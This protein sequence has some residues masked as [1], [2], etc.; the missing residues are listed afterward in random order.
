MLDAS[1]FDY[2][3]FDPIAWVNS[4][5]HTM[6]GSSSSGGGGGSGNPHTN[7]PLTSPSSRGKE[8]GDSGHHFDKRSR[9]NRLALRLN[10]MKDSVTRE[11]DRKSEHLVRGMYEAD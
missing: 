3:D 8:D 10:V 4:Q 11:I 6:E 9:L 2:D 7:T 1:Q 5:Y